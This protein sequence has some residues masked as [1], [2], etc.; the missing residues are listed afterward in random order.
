MQA[1]VLK[2][3]YRLRFQL[4]LQA[5][6]KIFNTF[7]GSIMPLLGGDIAHVGEALPNLEQDQTPEGNTL[8]LRYRNFYEDGL[9]EMEAW[10]EILGYAAK[11]HNGQ[12]REQA[13]FADEIVD[14]LAQAAAVPERDRNL[15]G[16][17]ISHL[18]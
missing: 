4:P 15:R 8:Y 1:E 13:K 7:Q 14:Y 2:T 16:E 6:R 9:A 5:Q 12:A 11:V 17:L 10:L 18:E 3:L